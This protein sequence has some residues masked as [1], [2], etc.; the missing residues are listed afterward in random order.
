MI[1]PGVRDAL[2]ISSSE[3]QIIGEA[4]GTED[5]LQPLERPPLLEHL[6]YRFIVGVAGI[7]IFNPD[8]VGL[9]VGDRRGEVRYRQDGNASRRDKP[10]HPPQRGWM[11]ES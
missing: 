6:V 10:R 5:V 11:S 1:V 9:R 8:S 2:A 7:E 3:C 4:Q